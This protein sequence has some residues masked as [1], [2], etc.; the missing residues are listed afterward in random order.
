MPS[1]RVE[2]CTTPLQNTVNHLNFTV[3]DN[4]CLI[5]KTSL[6]Y[7]QKTN[8]LTSISQLMPDFISYHKNA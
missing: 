6:I 4:T 1:A 2:Q 3:E 5:F 8:I 7:K